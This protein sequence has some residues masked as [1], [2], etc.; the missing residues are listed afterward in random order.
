MSPASA[1]EDVRLLSFTLVCLQAELTEQIRVR[2][3]THPGMSGA[4]SSNCSSN[5]QR[6]A[7]TWYVREWSPPRGL[8]LSLSRVVRTLC[9]M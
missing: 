3:V 4:R 6:D 1:V 7:K 9:E 5:S 8:I 2:Q